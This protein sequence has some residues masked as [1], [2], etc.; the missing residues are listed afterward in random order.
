LAG[1]G[2]LL[3]TGLILLFGVLLVVF[4][5]EVLHTVFMP[6][7]G[8][9]AR[10]LIAVWP[11]KMLFYAIYMGPL[12]RNQLLLVFLTPLLALTGLPLVLLAILA[13]FP[14]TL[15]AQGWLATLALVNG[16]GACGDIIAI[17]LVSLQIPAN[18]MVQNRGWR[19]Y[20]KVIQ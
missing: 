6:D 4:L 15:T 7:W 8:R 10:S 1:L 2:G 5:H 3:E 11:E 17:F 18:A 19:S 12:P 14:G 16:V 9:S 20:W 13:Q